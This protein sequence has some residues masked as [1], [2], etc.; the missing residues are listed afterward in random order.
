MKKAFIIHGWEGSPEEA[1][2]KWM[3][4]EL[5]S[6][7]FEV[8]ALSMPN[9]DEPKIEEWI[10]FLQEQIKEPNEETYFI[11]H[12]IG[13][14]AILRYL[15]KLPENTKVGG[16]VSIAPWMH[17][18]D[19]A[20]E[21]PEDKKIAQPWIENPLN[22]EKIKT[23]TDNFIAIFS[24]NDFCVPLSDKEIFEQKL[25][26]KIIVEHNKGH[27]TMENNIDEVPSALKAL[28]EMSNET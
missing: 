16:V 17:L 19:T 11:G 6:R 12:S 20:Y 14:Q 28:L 23:H 5:E 22:W 9:S 26:A 2:H 21:E 24:D 3:K 10:P 4:K 8:H 7:D 15:E 25:G 13:C 18:L 27:F 1:I